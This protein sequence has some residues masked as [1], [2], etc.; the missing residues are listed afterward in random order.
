MRRIIDF[1]KFELEVLEA[2]LSRRI[3]SLVLFGAAFVIPTIFLLAAMK[4]LQGLP[5]PGLA[6]GLRP[7]LGF[8]GLALMLKL[9]WLA[10]QA[11]LKDRAAL[12]RF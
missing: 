7:W 11:Y 2:V 3:R 12:L 6:D 5:L 9:M 4:V 8:M 10:T 1:L